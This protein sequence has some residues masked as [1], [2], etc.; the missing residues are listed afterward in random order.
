MPDLGSAADMRRPPQARPFADPVDGGGAPDLLPV[1]VADL[2]RPAADL[3][4]APPSP[5]LLEPAPQPSCGKL[6]QPTC[7]GMRCE[8]NLEPM[9]SGDICGQPVATSCVLP[10]SCGGPG[11]VACD[12]VGRPLGVAE[13]CRAGARARYGRCYSC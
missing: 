12:A 11:L 2:A 10:Q 4:P 3:S 9:G 13:F 6:G 1:A 5:D 8:G 7:D